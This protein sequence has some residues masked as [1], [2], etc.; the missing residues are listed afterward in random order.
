MKLA[1]DIGRIQTILLTRLIGVSVLFV[2]ASL[3][4]A[5]IK[6]G[7]IFVPAYLLRTGLLNCT[8]PLDESVLMDHV[9][10][11]V[12]GR[13]KSLESVSAFGWCGSAALGGLLAD[14]YDYAT[15][16]VFTATLQGLGALIQ[17]PLIALVPI[18][19][20]SKDKSEWP[21]SDKLEK[22]W[23]ENEAVW[24]FKHVASKT[25]TG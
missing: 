3:C 11:N 23:R 4:Y 19:E 8:Y 7:W 21:D 1:K 14:K 13:W 17:I 16:F 12:R 15:T 25:E 20:A 22:C 6:S 24:M 18:D 5:D 2:M 9:P 10:V